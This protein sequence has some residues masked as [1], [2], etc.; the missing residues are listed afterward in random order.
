VGQVW[1]Y[2]WSKTVYNSTG[3]ECANCHGDFNGWTA[4]VTPHADR[5]DRGDAHSFTGTLTYPCADCHAIGSPLYTY[6]S[7]NADWNDAAGETSHHGD[8]SITLNNPVN[9]VFFTEISF[10]PDRIGCLNSTA[11]CHN[12]STLVGDTN[13]TYNV[14]TTGFPTDLVVGDAPK[15]E[16]STCHGG[17]SPGGTDKIGYW[18]NNPNGTGGEKDRGKHE[19]HIAALADSVF[20]G[21]TLID[22]LNDT[23]EGFSNTKQ[24]EICAYCHD[25]PGGA[26]HKSGLPADVSS[27]YA[28]WDV[29]RSTLDDASY[30]SP[31][32]AGDDTCSNVDCHF[33]K[34]TEDGLYGWYDAGTSACIMCHTDIELNAPGTGETHVAHMNSATL[35][36]RPSLCSDC[37][38][39]ATSWGPDVAPDDGRHLSGGAM[40]IIGNIINN[41]TVFYNATNGC[42]TNVCHNAG[43][44]TALPADNDYPWGTAIAGCDFCH[45]ATPAVTFDAHNAHMGN[46]NYVPAG[47]NECHEPAKKNTHINTFVEYNSAITVPASNDGWDQSC[48]NDCHA[49]SAPSGTKWNSAT[50]ANCL[51]C[52]SGSYVGG[53]DWRGITGLSYLPQTGLHV[54]VP[55]V[56]GVTH[57][58]SFLYNSGALTGECITCHTTTPSDS[59]I[60]GAFGMTYNSGTNDGLI[61]FAGDVNYQDFPKPTCSPSGTLA[62]CHTDGGDWSRIWFENSG[63]YATGNGQL[64]CAGCHGYW[65]AGSDGSGWRA[66]TSHAEAPAL[67]TR[68]SSTTHNPGQI[69]N[70]DCYACH[71]LGGT[72]DT[73]YP[74]TNVSNDWNSIELGTTLH[75]DGF[76]TMNQSSSTPD[77]PSDNDHDIAGLSGCKT[78]HDGAFD[79]DSDGNNYA[80]QAS[81]FPLAV[82]DG[83]DDPFSGGGSCDACHGTGGEYWPSASRGD[84]FPDR[85]GMHPE[86]MVAMMA[87]GIAQTTA[88]NYCHQFPVGKSNYDGHQSGAPADTYNSVT[89]FYNSIID[90]S[91]KDTDGYYNIAEFGDPGEDTCSN[92]DCHFNNSYTPHW[93]NDSIAPER[94][95]LNSATLGVEP[96]SVVVNWF[97]PGDDA[98]LPN[99]TAYV[100]DMRMNADSDIFTSV[101][102]FNTATVVGGVPIT[103][104]RGELTE[105]TVHNLAPD[106]TYFF[107]I[108][109]KDTAGNWSY[110]SNNT[111]SVYVPTTATTFDETPPEFS[112][113]DRATKGD[114]GEAINLWWTAAEDHSMYDPVSKAT[115][116]IYYKVWLKDLENGTLDLNDVGDDIYIVRSNWPDT[117]IELQ[118][119]P[120]GVFADHVY[121]LGVQACDVHNNCDD[122]NKIVSVTP[123]KKKEPVGTVYSFNANAGSTQLIQEGSQGTEAQ[124]SIS[125]SSANPTTFYGPVES[126]DVNYAIDS[127]VI[128]LAPS[129]QDTP[130]VTAQIGTCD[131][132]GGWNGAVAGKDPLPVQTAKRSSQ[133]Y[134][135]K[136]ADATGVDV[137]GGDAI[138]VGLYADIAVTA[139]YGTSGT[140]GRAT[141]NRTPVN[142]PPT[143]VGVVDFSMLPSDGAGNGAIVK[144]QWTAATDGDDDPALPED[145]HYDVYGSVTGNGNYDYVIAEEIDGTETYLEWDTQAAGL[146]GLDS[147]PGHQGTDVWIEFRSGDGYD[148]TSLFYDIPTALDEIDD[149]APGKIEDLHVVARPKAGAVL[150]SWTSPGDDYQNNGRAAGYDIRYSEATIDD[151]LVYNSITNLGWVKGEPYPDFGKHVVE[152]EV[153]GLNPNTTTYFAMK[154]IDEAGNVSEMS[155]VASDVAGPRCGMCHTTGPSVVESEGNHKLHGHTLADCADCHGAVSQNYGLDH[156][157]GVLTMGYLQDG[158]VVATINGAIVEYYNTSGV[159]MYQDTDGFG[160]FGTG[161]YAS[162]G[163][164]TDNGGCFNFGSQG[165]SGCHGSAGEDPD[166]GGSLPTYETPIWLGS[167]NLDCARCHGDPTRVTDSFYGLHFDG[168]IFNAELRGGPGTTPIP[169]DVPDQIKGSPKVD[170]RGNYDDI[171]LNGGTVDERKYIGH[172]EKH[173][174]YSFRFSKGDSCNLCHQGHYTDQ[175]KLDGKHGNKIVEI[176]MD[177]QASGPLAHYNAGTTGV[178][179]TCYDMSPYNCHPADAEPEWDTDDNFPCVGCHTMGNLLAN[180]GHYI[181]PINGIDA[182]YNYEGNPGNCTW[183][184]FPGHPTDDVGGT[185]LILPNNSQVGIDYMSGGIH[186]RKDPGNNSA[187]PADGSQTQAELC[188]SCHESQSPKIS[189]WNTDGAPL[190]NTATIPLNGTDYD[191]G[192]VTNP[193]WTQA[194]WHSAQSTAGGGGANGDD[195]FGYK[196]GNIQSTHSTNLYNGVSA[197]TWN[198]TDNQYEEAVDAVED[199][200]CH[201]CH[202]VHNMNFADGDTSTGPPFLRGSWVRNPYLE[203]GA[204]HTLSDY[205]GAMNDFMEVPRGG[206]NYKEYGGFQIDQNNIDGTGPPTTG[207]GLG[208]SAGLCTLCHGSV[209]D[210]LDVSINGDENLWIGANGHSNSALGGT[211][212]L[213]Y[214]ANIFRFTDDTTTWAPD[215]IYGRSPSGI[216]CQ[217]TDDYM[218]GDAPIMGYV[219][220]MHSDGVTTKRGDGLRASYDLPSKGF[221]VLPLIVGTDY[222]YEDFAWGVVQDNTKVQKGYHSFTCSKCHNPHASRLPKLM[223]TNCLDTKWNTWDDGRRPETPP[224]KVVNYNGVTMNSDSRYRTLS[225]TGAAQNCHRLGDPYQGTTEGNG[226]T[227]G[228]GSGWNRVTPWNTSTTIT[229]PP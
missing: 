58:D 80:F 18:P 100:Y 44:G 62:S 142:T 169:A 21:E 131:G 78:C 17:Y 200:L 223:I 121:E 108:R 55:V 11:G 54:A 224:G 147:R 136:L 166:G 75:G 115:T 226:D 60:N 148:H 7:I 67:S 105:V 70:F 77:D 71:V 174:N 197:V 114:E 122:N 47:C 220:A 209:V 88:C 116:P 25:T 104:L 37:H 1:T 219:N 123:T 126:F 192:T 29:P 144:M 35:F 183:C 206:P 125:T 95:T 188:W 23:G 92:I 124:V 186:L 34:P 82:V 36:G 51:D 229:A 187:G 204:P 171:P 134:S 205:S 113:A 28:M 85:P 216:M 101:P 9:S 63:S 193:D 2:N 189:E 97:S 112:G 102:N 39:P 109:A 217:S 191:Y 89:N 68:G 162:V 84:A 118:G 130:V 31:E 159:L 151:G 163:D 184:H 111:L 139:T 210:E 81:T 79:T 13:H 203:D 129:G 73:E 42:G 15:V 38:D 66:G 14:T 208:N 103:Y 87:K 138:C 158:P 110:L 152:Y 154:T 32:L 52:H 96:G 156:Q 157:D 199:I 53:N 221:N 173:L 61:N 83:T 49:S 90:K 196:S 176:E 8:G 45:A 72:D 164:G 50:L 135:W 155:N 5:P 160:G 19:I 26:N 140:G 76:I 228:T 194:I 143:Q 117:Q 74:W 127:F 190:N 214:A 198:A 146:Y 3:A 20:N 145:L 201:N 41:T 149:V 69:N 172:H 185:A 106:T 56:S 12:E 128:W 33:N 120:D 165:L 10:D 178:P 215:T 30:F 86:H 6:N 211:A 98:N 94:I 150:L 161:D 213:T 107:N 43:D 24:I 153:T 177:L 93:Y 64:P 4:G 133:L 227:P 222:A 141:I 225:N 132:S 218:C 167:A 195:R 91:M 22:L 27:M 170:N 65:T 59:H 16:C 202:D 175:D 212:S 119:A 99:T 57:D 137:T 179:G 48:T 46:T 40:Q 182:G 168:T 180:I 207:L 181:D